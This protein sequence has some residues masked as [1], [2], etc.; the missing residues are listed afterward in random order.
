[1]PTDASRRLDDAEIGTS[2]LN[3][4]A[5]ALLA[6]PDHETFAAVCDALADVADTGDDVD[7]VRFVD[8]VDRA[9]SLAVACGLVRA[10]G[11]DAV[12]TIMTQAFKRCRVHKRP[13]AEPQPPVRAL[14]AGSTVEA[15]MFSLR[16][17]G[18]AALLER[19]CLDR[20]AELS[21]DQIRYV[22]AR[23]TKLRPRYPTITDE[24]H[25]KLEAQA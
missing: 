18:A 3:A 4:A 19:A 21:S 16:E 10:T 8:A 13:P 15:L 9:Q 23:L 6:T 2:P 24:M 14:A 1:M 5:A 20:L 11:Q 22:I 25:S 12:Q 17:N 7:R